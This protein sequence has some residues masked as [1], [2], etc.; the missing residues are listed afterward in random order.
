MLG[1]ICLPTSLVV[2]GMSSES[3]PTRLT[4]EAPR[5]SSNVVVPV[6]WMGPAPTT[7]VPPAPTEEQP[8][9]APDL[10]P[11]ILCPTGQFPYQPCLSDLPPPTHHHGSS[12]GSSG[13]S[14]SSSGCSAPGPP[15]PDYIKSRESGG[16]YGLNDPNGHYGAWQFSPETWQG[17]GGSGNP[18]NASPA[19]QDCRA[20]VLWNNGSGRSNWQATA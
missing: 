5:A 10:G 12:Q 7:T 11:P 3:T 14:G 8:L 18:A 4:T 1:A 15:P 2:L 9:P 13:S 19:E 17:V 16:D 6:D 20:A